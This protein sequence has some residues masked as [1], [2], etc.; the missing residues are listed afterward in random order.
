M[1]VLLCRFVL[2][3]SAEIL[4]QTGQIV[5]IPACVRGENTRISASG[6]TCVAWPDIE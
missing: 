4:I 1:S 5:G 6:D 3:L 2:H